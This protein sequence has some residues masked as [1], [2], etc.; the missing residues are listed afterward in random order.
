MCVWGQ[1]S[2][3]PGCAA[4]ERGC[5]HASC[6]SGHPALVA[7]EEPPLT[8]QTLGKSSPSSCP[9]LSTWPPPPHPPGRARPFPRLRGK[10]LANC[11][12]GPVTPADDPSRGKGQGTGPGIQGFAHGSRGSSLPVPHELWQAQVPGLPP[13]P[14]APT[15]RAGRCSP[16]PTSA[17]KARPCATHTGTGSSIHPIH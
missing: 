1:A 13:P 6:R 7:M 17:P 4:Q 9:D 10:H 12:F 8:S 16:P 14:I 2:P 5:P 15:C 3:G 11:R